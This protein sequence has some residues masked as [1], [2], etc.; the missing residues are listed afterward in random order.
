MRLV[1]AVP[2]V[3]CNKC[4]YVRRCSI[5]DA[6]GG[7]DGYCSKGEP[8]EEDKKPMCYAAC[9]HLT[10]QMNE[11]YDDEECYCAATKNIRGIKRLMYIGFL[12]DV[13][14][15]TCECVWLNE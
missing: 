12:G 10:L 4:T 8:A 9:K 5:Q 11:E 2:V 13:R 1:D 7:I 15:G 14:K 3:R 6:L